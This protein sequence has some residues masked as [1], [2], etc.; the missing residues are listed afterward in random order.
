MAQKKI[1]AGV[2][3]LL[4]AAM[5]LALAGCGVTVAGFGPFGKGRKAAE[6]ALTITEKSFETPEECVEYF[7]ERLAALDSQG[8]LEAFA[9]VTAAENWDLTSYADRVGMFLPYQFMAPGEYEEYTALN[10]V[11]L[12]GQRAGEIRT[13][14]YTLVA[15]EELAEQIAGSSPVQIDDDYYS[16]SRL[17]RDL[18][19]EDLALLELLDIYTPSDLGTSRSEQ[20]EYKRNTIYI[21]NADDIQELV[22]HYDL[23]GREY[24]CG[25]SLACY[26][27]RWLIRS[28]TA[29]LMGVTIGAKPVTGR[30]RDMF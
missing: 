22:A 14:V 30:V 24:I 20:S 10:A 12:M 26:E 21:S 28:L 13:L 2:C 18:N 1:T 15:P 9:T 25:F 16:A 6:P 3:L 23:D 8:A 4:S 29:P 7:T 17:V 27:G 19:P 5:I 11:H